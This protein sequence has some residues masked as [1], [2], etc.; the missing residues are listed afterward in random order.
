MDPEVPVDTFRSPDLLPSEDGPDAIITSPLS[1]NAD[2]PD[3]KAIEPL[4]CLD[5]DVWM[6]TDPP[7]PLSLV[8]ISKNV[9][10]L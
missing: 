2:E 3:V 8:D 1:P 7:S 5:D 10:T 4:S 6:E 9:Q